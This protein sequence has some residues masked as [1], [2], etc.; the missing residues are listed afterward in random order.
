MKLGVPEI[1][2]GAAEDAQKSASYSSIKKVSPRSA[3]NFSISAFWYQQ[4]T[5]KGELKYFTTGEVLLPK[6]RDGQETANMDGRKVRM[7][8]R[9]I[10]RESASQ[11]FMGL[12]EFLLLIKVMVVVK[13]SGR[14]VAA[15]E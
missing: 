4:G 3:V 14:F 2:S 6:V 1:R 15:C 13:T 9:P 7:R 11:K 10:K 12:C 8:T 5:H